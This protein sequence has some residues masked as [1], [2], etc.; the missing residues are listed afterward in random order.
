MSNP[1]FHRR[2]EAKRMADY[3]ASDRSSSG[4]FLSAPRRTGKTTFILEDLIPDL[5]SRGFEVIYVDLWSNVDND[6]NIDS[7]SI[8]Y[9]LEALRD[10]MLIWSSARGFMPSMIRNTAIGSFPKEASRKI[11]NCCGFVNLTLT[12]GDIHVCHQSCQKRYR[13]NR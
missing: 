12:R 6:I 13:A 2:S 5:L 3:I 7:S 8:K 4:L 11:R 1:V 10:K 9:A